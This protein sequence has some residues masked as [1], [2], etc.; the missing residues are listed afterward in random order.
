MN[1]YEFSDVFEIHPGA[2]EFFDQLGPGQIGPLLFQALPDVNFW[3]KDAQGKFVYVNKAFCQECTT[4]SESE[5]LGKTDLD[6]FPT[7]LAAVFRNDDMSVVTSGQPVWNKRELVNNVVGGVEWRAT[8]KV[9]LR[10]SNGKVIGT[11]GLSRRLGHSEGCPVP[12][13]H[14]DMAA[15]VGAIYKCLDRDVRVAEL[16]EAANTSV[17]TL[18]RTFKEHMGTTPKRFIM[19]AKIS[20][21]CERLINTSLSV[22]EVSASVGYTDNASFTRAFRRLM[23]Q[24][25]TDYRRAYRR[26]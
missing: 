2:Q 10:D 3:I 13:Q 9:P 19:Q 4:C 20:T 23:G 26:K 6:L 12:S 18:E 15:I 11:A 25:P 14:R 22:K 16:A 1:E 17:S 7:E 21:A 5:V 8:S 24:S